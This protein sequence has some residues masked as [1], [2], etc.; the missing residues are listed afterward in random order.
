MKITHINCGGEI[1]ESTTI[2]PCEYLPEDSN[3]VVLVCAYQCAK[4]QIEIVSDWQIEFVP[5]S[6][7][8][9][10]QIESFICS[11]RRG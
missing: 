7:M 8:D 4:C 11:R 6:E 2:P 3:C 1:T 10:A 5:E 9:K